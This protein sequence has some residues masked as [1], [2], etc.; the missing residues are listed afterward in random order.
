MLPN[1][2]STRPDPTRPDFCRNFIPLEIS[3]PWLVFPD[4][5]IL[6]L[7]QPWVHRA[8]TETEKE[9]K[10]IGF[11]Q[12]NYHETMASVLPVMFRFR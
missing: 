9:T 6:K 4:K 3:R 2:I 10:R 12:L 7:L 8:I 11:W 5:A 1:P